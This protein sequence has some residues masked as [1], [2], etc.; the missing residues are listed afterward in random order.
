MV[1]IR[2]RPT[3]TPKRLTSRTIVRPQI[4]HQI[5]TNT[6]KKPTNR[7]ANNSNANKNANANRLTNRNQN[8][9][10]NRAA[11][12]NSNAN[13]TATP[14]HTNANLLES[15][16]KT[17]TNAGSRLP[18]L[19]GGL[20]LRSNALKLTQNDRNSPIDSFGK[21]F[22]TREEIAPSK[23]GASCFRGRDGW[24]ICAQYYGRFA[25]RKSN[26]PCNPTAY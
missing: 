8:G 2:R 5:Q 7:N 24:A 19:P 1:N 21:L 11:N 3:R 26:F 15:Q 10:S 13:S 20:Q 23:A 25:G 17:N 9:N 14:A 6:E 12:T 18:V 22:K 4:P 16:P